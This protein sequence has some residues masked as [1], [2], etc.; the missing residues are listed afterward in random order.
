M[1]NATRPQNTPDAAA[2]A[3]VVPAA[4]YRSTVTTIADARKHLTRAD[5]EFWKMD[6]TDDDGNSIA[7]DFVTIETN[8]AAY[9]DRL[10]KQS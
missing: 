4:L 2:E 1:I 6:I 7:D 3:A 5:G 10:P 9:A 8:A